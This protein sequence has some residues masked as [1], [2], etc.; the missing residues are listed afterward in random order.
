[1][2]TAAARQEASSWEDLPSER[3][4]DLAWRQG[5][6]SHRRVG[7]AIAS[8][9]QRHILQISGSN[10]TN[11]TETMAP[12]PGAAVDPRALSKSQF[13][14]LLSSGTAVKL[15]MIPALANI[16]VRLR[17]GSVR[18]QDLYGTSSF[19]FDSLDAFKAHVKSFGFTFPGSNGL[20]ITFNPGSL[21][22]NL[23]DAPMALAIDSANLSVSKTVL[24][25]PVVYFGPAMAFSVCNGVS[26]PLDSTKSA[27]GYIPLLLDSSTLAPTQLA[28]GTVNLTAQSIS[29]CVSHWSLY[30][31]AVAPPG[32]PNA[33]NTP[34]CLA[35]AIAFPVSFFVAICVL[36]GVCSYLSWKQKEP[37]V[38]GDKRQPVSA[39]DPLGALASRPASPLAPAAPLPQLFVSP[40]L[41]P[42][43]NTVVTTSRGVDILVTMVGP[44]TIVSTPRGVPSV[45]GPASMVTTPRGIATA[46]GA[47]PP[48]PRT[49]P[50]WSL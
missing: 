12:F 17:P 38:P 8:P 13:L 5:S 7:G 16:P 48:T 45:V 3:R 29:V 44:A 10:V 18:F 37:R 42:L 14:Q 40:F 50:V 32:D 34:S 11:G 31:G 27:A 33:C 21:P 39:D 47:S 23:T 28:G 1:M 26:L 46:P 49:V 2:P 20:S 24:A 9:P 30:S 35:M 4:N 36:L 41:P 43:P 15:T 22:D 19:P 25:G 6:G